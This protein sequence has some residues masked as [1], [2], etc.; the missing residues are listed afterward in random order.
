M[1]RTYTSTKTYTR[2]LFLKKQIRQV[3]RETTQISDDMLG[4]LLEAVGK[5]WIDQ[6]DVY[7]LDYNNLCRA[8][9]NMDIDWDEYNRQMAIGKITIAVDT[10]WENDLLPQADGSI[11]AFNQYVQEY[12]LRTEWRISYTDWIYNNPSKLA[13]A[14]D[15]LGTS[16]GKP[17]KWA[18]RTAN[19]YVKNKI[20]P[21]FGIGLY[22]VE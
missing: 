8:R 12:G 19:D 14:R 1:A 4:K 20:F 9:L 21:E 16:P 18:G 3:L 2:I 13:Q 6:I 5:K 22:F 10:R 15:F 11:W 7:A 17:I